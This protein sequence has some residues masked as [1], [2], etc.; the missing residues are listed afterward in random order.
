MKTVKA[1]KD[2]IG[3]LPSL[4]C[5]ATVKKGDV[6]HVFELSEDKVKLVGLGHIEFNLC[7]FEVIA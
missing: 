7:D 4:P 5:A 1:K 2:T 3:S 6:Y